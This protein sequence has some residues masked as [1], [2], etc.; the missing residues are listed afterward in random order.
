VWAEDKQQVNNAWS[1]SFQKKHPRGATEEALVLFGHG[2]THAAMSLHHKWPSEHVYFMAPEFA[3]SA[4]GQYKKAYTLLEEQGAITVAGRNSPPTGVEG[5]FFAMALC[6]QV[7]ALC[8][9]LCPPGDEPRAGERGLYST[10][11]WAMATLSHTR[12]AVC[13]NRQVHVYGFNVAEQLDP[14]VQYHYHDKV[15]GEIGA[16]SF[17]FQAIFLRMLAAEGHFALCVPGLATDQCAMG[18]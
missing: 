17:N 10:V 12:R 18:V 7:C 4:R 8:L 6:Q 15:E 9:F 16:H 11:E 5:I 1:R 14:S 3:A 13:R 2:S